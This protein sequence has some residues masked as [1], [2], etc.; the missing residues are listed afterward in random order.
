MNTNFAAFDIR[1]NIISSKKTSKKS[2]LDVLAKEFGADNILSSKVTEFHPSYT[3]SK[4]RN[5]IRKI[6]LK[7]DGD[8]CC[9]CNEPVL[10]D[11]P[12]VHPKACSI[13]HVKRKSKGGSNS[14]DNLALA[15]KV[16]NNERHK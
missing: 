11:V 14:L 4:G 7:R 10:F 15:H 5:A 1:F 3:K 16:C 2:I 13:E 12:D 9:W 6:L 8:L